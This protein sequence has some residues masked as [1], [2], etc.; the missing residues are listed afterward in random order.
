LKTDASVLSHKVKQTEPLVSGKFKPSLKKRLERILDRIWNLS[1]SSSTRKDLLLF[2]LYPL[3]CV[4]LNYLPLLLSAFRP[5]I[6]M[7]PLPLVRLYSRSPK[8]NTEPDKLIWAW[9]EA[10]LYLTLY[11]ILMGT[12]YCSLI[13]FGSKENS[14]TLRWPIITRISPFQTLKSRWVQ[15]LG[16]A[17]GW[18]L[19]TSLGFF[20]SYSFLLGPLS[21]GLLLYCGR[22]LSLQINTI[23]FIGFIGRFDLFVLTFSSS[24]AIFSLFQVCKEGLGMLLRL[25]CC[26]VKKLSGSRLELIVWQIK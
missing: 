4:L 26:L 5:R 19:S 3:S 1:S 2:I 10:W 15:S 16:H 14:L 9:N 24:A 12:L 18:A 20:L 6:I 17:L 7:S 11:S 22:A 23:H 21:R 13:V 8:S 25:V